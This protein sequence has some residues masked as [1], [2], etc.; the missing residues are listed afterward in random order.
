MAGGETW[1][2]RAHGGPVP[3]NR[4]TACDDAGVKMGKTS[5][6]I[7]FY[8]LYSSGEAGLKMETC[9]FSLL[10]TVREVSGLSLFLEM[11]R[12]SSHIT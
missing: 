9:I 6:A 4:W 11:C 3:V 1:F 7:L 5:D 8:S 2:P 10:R 12:V